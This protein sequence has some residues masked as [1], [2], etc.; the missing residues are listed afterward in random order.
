M[1]KFCIIDFNNPMT[2]RR[3]PSLIGYM[4]NK[5]GVSVDTVTEL[6]D[7]AY[8]I[9]TSDGTKHWGSNTRATSDFLEPR[10]GDFIDNFEM[11][12]APAVL[13]EIENV[14][15]FYDSKNLNIGSDL[16]LIQVK[17]IVK[18]A[19]D[20]GISLEVE[21]INPE[22]K[23]SDRIYRVFPTEISETNNDAANSFIYNQLEILALLSLRKTFSTQCWLFFHS[24]QKSL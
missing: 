11:Q 19:Q 15:R 1:P 13:D 5:Q 18:D 3:H 7:S 14:Q 21:T 17:D 10:I 20:Y 16:N 2:G 23:P 24:F 8:S 4:L 6:L 22:D 12:V 9:I